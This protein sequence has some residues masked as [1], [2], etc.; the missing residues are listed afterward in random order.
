[1]EEG[2][3]EGRGEVIAY[4]PKTCH[5]PLRLFSMVEATGSEPDNAFCTK[6]SIVPSNPVREGCDKMVEHESQ[7]MKPHD[8]V[9]LCSIVFWE[10]Q[11]FLREFEEGG[12]GHFCIKMKRVCLST[13]F[14]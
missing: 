13:S 4:S 14:N 9:A 3:E 5:L 1:M 7:L 11:E 6:S 2:R 12:G 8:N 10:S